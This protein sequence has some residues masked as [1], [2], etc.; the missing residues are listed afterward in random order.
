MIHI[1]RHGTSSRLTDGIKEASPGRWLAVFAGSCVALLAFVYLALWAFNG[2]QGVGLD[3]PGT[4]ALALGTVL[5]AGLGVGLMALIFY[6]DRSE[7]DRG[8]GG[9]GRRD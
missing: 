7:R 3:W 4:I 6:S 8:I 2:F 1:Q 9:A 5:A